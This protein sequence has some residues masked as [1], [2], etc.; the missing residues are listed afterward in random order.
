MLKLN[1]S[2]ASWKIV[3]IELSRAKRAENFLK[4]LHFSPKFYKQV[5]V[6]LFI[7]FSRRGQIIYFQY[8]QGQNIYF[9]KVP[10]PPP[11]E[12]NGRPL[13]SMFEVCAVHPSCSVKYI[14][15]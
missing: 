11:S 14:R 3:E 6:R 10:A 1:V 4:I 7:F 5:K 8:F 15:P 13:K 2:E 9:Q 12:S